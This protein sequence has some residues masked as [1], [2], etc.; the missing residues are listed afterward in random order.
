LIFD[1]ARFDYLCGAIGDD[2]D[3]GKELRTPLTFV[4]SSPT[5]TPQLGEASEVQS[6][7]WL[8]DRLSLITFITATNG[9]LEIVARRQEPVPRPRVD[10]FCISR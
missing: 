6:S 7:S 3:E 9:R 4:T 1:L 2:G 10:D 8:C 5:L